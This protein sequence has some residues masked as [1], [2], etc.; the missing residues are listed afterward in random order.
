MAYQILKQ[1]HAPGLVSRVVLDVSGRR[2]EEAER[3]AVTD[4]KFGPG[5]ISFTRADES[6]PMPVRPE[7]EVLFS[8]PGFNFSADL[9]EYTLAVNGLPAGDYDL[10][11]DGEPLGTFSAEELALGLNLSRNCGC[12]QRQSERLLDMV[13]DKDLL[14]FRRWRQ[15]QLGTPVPKESAATFAAWQQK[16]LARDDALIALKET[17]IDA[18]RHPGSH[19]WLLTRVSTPSAATEMASLWP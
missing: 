4:L 11:L 15:V 8:V 16:E 10:H 7:S 12:L 6:L 14:Y 1:L 5:R 17:E 2:L 19:K 18:L 13:W 9:N 3:C